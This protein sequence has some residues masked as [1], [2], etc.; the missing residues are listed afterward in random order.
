MTFYIP[1]FLFFLCKFLA[2]TVTSASSSQFNVQ[3]LIYTSAETTMTAGVVFSLLIYFKLQYIKCLP[4]TVPVLLLLWKVTWI[5]TSHGVH[6]QSRVFCMLH[7]CLLKTMS[8]SLKAL[9]TNAAPTHNFRFWWS[10]CFSEE[11]SICFLTA[12]MG[13]ITPLSLLLVAT[14][15]VKSCISMIT[16][17]KSVNLTNFMENPTPCWGRYAFWKREAD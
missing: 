1:L 14:F 12:R 6:A 7:T 15:I 13:L 4:P 5:F 3:Q 2:Y 8:M 10:E 17:C 11:G 9:L 16:C